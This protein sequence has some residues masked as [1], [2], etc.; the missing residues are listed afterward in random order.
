MDICWHKRPLSNLRGMMVKSRRFSGIP[1]KEIIKEMHR[2][3]T[4][5]TDS[6]LCYARD[7][8]KKQ[9]RTSFFISISDPNGVLMDFFH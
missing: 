3:V 2:T 9:H 6:L 5:T 4:L 1:R 8:P 7:Q